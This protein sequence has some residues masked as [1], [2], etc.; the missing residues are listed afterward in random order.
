ME[1]HF[2]AAKRLLEELNSEPQGRRN[3]CVY[4]IAYYDMEHCVVE[5]RQVN[6]T[7]YGMARWQPVGDLPNAAS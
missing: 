5:Y 7:Y 6:V 4:R 1:L 3:Q 2:D